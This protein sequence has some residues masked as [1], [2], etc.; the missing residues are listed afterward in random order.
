MS[1]DVAAAV[2]TPSAIA[3]A[4][5]IDVVASSVVAAVSID[6]S[7]TVAALAR[8]KAAQLLCL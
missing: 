6:I 5:P 7:T 8:S 4:V 1:I 2:A 3:A